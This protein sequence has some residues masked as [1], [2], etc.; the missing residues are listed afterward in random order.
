MNEPTSSNKKVTAGLILS[1]TFGALFAL[2]GITTVSTKSLPGLVMLIMAVILLPP[3]VKFLQDRWKFHISRRV[4]VAVIVV[5]FIIY[6]SSANTVD[7][8]STVNTGI[9]KG[10]QQ[11][12]K[13]VVVETATE[14]RVEQ[15]Q[16]VV[17]PPVTKRLGV[18]YDQMMNYLSN[19]FTMEKSSPVN[20][21]DRYMATTTNGLAILEIIGN[22][23]NISQTTLLLGLPNDNSTVA[24]E[25]SALLLLFLK[26]AVPE[27][28][29]R[30]TWA[31]ASLKKI[32]ET[33]SDEEKKLYGGKSIEMS[34]LKELGM[35][36]VTVKPE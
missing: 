19:F 5:G 15:P 12:S 33:S 4:R 31:T 14:P 25:N 7:V 13:E 1:W 27:W 18:S 17:A 9:E 10:K 8:S 30:D 2:I 32:A 21:V 22:K 3:S 23:D 28:K 24:I 35:L 29:D 16:V 20:G 26:N 36:S 11:V 34:F 6:G